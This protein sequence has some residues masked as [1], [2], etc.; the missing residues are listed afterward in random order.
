M[1]KK[2]RELASY[3]T[4]GAR[5]AEFLDMRRAKHFSPGTIEW[6]EGNLRAFFNWCEERSLRNPTEITRP[7][8][9]EAGQALDHRLATQAAG[10]GAGLLQVDGQVEHDSLQSG[11]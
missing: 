2:L 5:A 3:G 9:D 7:I 11:F 4:L 8:P 6:N 10:C 1:A